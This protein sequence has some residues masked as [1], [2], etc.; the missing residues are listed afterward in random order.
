MWPFCKD[1][2]TE[3]LYR[4]E[5]GYVPEDLLQFGLDHLEAALALG[6]GNWEHLHSAGYLAHLALELLFKSWLLEQMSTFPKTHSLRKLRQDVQKIDNSFKL[7]K[8]HN[9]LLDYLDGLYELR[10]PNRKN[11]TEIGQEDLKLVEELVGEIWKRLPQTLTD[12]YKNIPT[13]R[14][15]GAPVLSNPPR[16]IP[17]P[18]RTRT[19]AFVL[20]RRPRPSCG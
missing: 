3:R 4:A 6:N 7:T 9:K 18:W 19:G 16:D 20:L 2:K 1:K 8:P 10:Y 12:K 11:P 15:P 17:V 5:D 14:K 13:N